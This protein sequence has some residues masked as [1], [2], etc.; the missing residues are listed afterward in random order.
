M[1]P[2]LFFYDEKKHANIAKFYVKNPCKI[3]GNKYGNDFYVVAY[4]KNADKANDLYLG[5]KV[6]VS[7]KLSTW[8]KFDKKGRSQQGITVIANELHILGVLLD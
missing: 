4:M 5:A 1:I 3:G 8:S 6:S 7:G 2:S